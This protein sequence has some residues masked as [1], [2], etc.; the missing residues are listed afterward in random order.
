MNN[1]NQ[2]IDLARKA[3]RG[4]EAAFRKLYDL[5]KNS[6]FTV[7]LRYAKNRECAQDYLQETFI[8][9]YRNLSKFDDKKGALYTWMKRVTINTCLMDL[10]KGTL[11]FVSL[12]EAN[13]IENQSAGIL[14]ELSMKEMLELVQ[15]LPPGYRT[16]FNLYVID[17]FSHKE[18]AEQLDIA[19]STSKSQLMKARN[20]LQK[21]ILT[22]PHQRQ[23]HYG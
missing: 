6:L 15:E 8:N 13:H 20:L 21:K 5:Y 23:H 7:C 2:H 10:R 18:I 16:I 22:N 1:T 12:T 3:A 9:I 19:V 17:G 14:S 4:N 11:Y